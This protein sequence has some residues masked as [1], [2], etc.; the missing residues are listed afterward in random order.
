MASEV[1][2]LPDVD[3]G[4]P[5]ARA[6]CC[7]NRQGSVHDFGADAVSTCNGDGGEVSH[8]DVLFFLKGVWVV[9]TSTVCV[10]I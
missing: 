4:G 6:R 3:E 7:E 9:K 10:N 1:L 2:G 5:H 8:A